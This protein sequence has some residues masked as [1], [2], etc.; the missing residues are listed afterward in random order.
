MSNIKKDKKTNKYYFVLDGGRDVVTG[1]RKQYRRKGFTSKKQAEIALS[2]LRVE[3]SE[4][5]ETGLGNK[6]FKIYSHD[7]LKSK[8]L[9][10]KASTIK[11]YEEQ[12]HYNITPYLG[13]FKLE[14]IDEKVLQ[15]YIMELHQ[16]RGL[17]PATIRTA[18]GIVGEIIKTLTKKGVLKS[19]ILEE[20]SLPRQLKTIKV[21]EQ[22]QIE[23]FLNAPQ[24]ILNLSRH[25]IG[26]VILIKTGMRMGEVL[27]LRWQDIDFENKVILIRQTLTRDSDSN[28]YYLQDEGKTAS[29]IRMVYIP[30]SLIKDILTH[31]ELIDK[32]KEIQGVHYNDNDF[33]ICTREGNMV[34]PNNFRRSFTTTIKQLNV[35]KIRLHDLRHSHATYLL[36]IG[37]N[38]KIIQERLGHKN[39]NVT[40]NTYSHALPAMQLAAIDK[41]DEAFKG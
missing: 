20:V 39:I 27:A 31:K 3:I 19:G 37:V 24:K 10:L 8:K 5:K 28:N 16:S 26:L 29:A 7:W 22:K 4:S 11:N 12:F 23:E 35:P 40:L 1:K 17:A 32:E 25:Y 30:D 14:D 2:K 41:F 21:W 33:V 6:T 15:H 36:S 38:V 34:H 18:F 13:H 9:K